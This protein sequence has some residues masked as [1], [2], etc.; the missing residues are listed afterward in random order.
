MNIRSIKLH[1]IKMP[2]KTPFS[3]HLET[4]TEREGI[5]IEVTGKDG[6]KGYGESVAFTSPWYTEET[7]KTCWHMMVDFLIPLLRDNMP[8]TPHDTANIFRKY[9][10]NL[11]AKAGMESA[12]WDLAAKRKGM[13]LFQYIG[14]VGESIPAGVVI[15]GK[16]INDSLNQIEFYLSEGFT[17]VKVKISPENDIK[18]IQI[19]RRHFPDLDLMADANSAYTLQDAERLLALDEFDL[20]MVE[21]P[22]AHDDIIEHAKLQ[23]LIRT[24]ICL[25]ESITSFESAR[26]AIELGSCGVMNIKAGRVGGLGP[27]MKIHDYCREHDIPVWCGGMIEFGVSRAHSIALASLPGFTIPGDISGSSRYWEQDII[28]PEIEVKHGRILIP[29][30]PGIGFEIHERR[31]AEVTQFTEEYFM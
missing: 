31:L 15:A 1:H 20:L 7:V 6:V 2:L 18:L 3:T 24:P 29:S 14:G 12:F 16:T 23:K 17:R 21:Q 10:G 4:V 9:R 30:S 5:I 8:S 26:K 13:P 11:M 22:L 27:A 25:D 19:I 28:M